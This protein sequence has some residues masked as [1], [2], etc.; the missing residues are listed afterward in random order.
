VRVEGAVRAGGDVRLWGTQLAFLDPNGNDNGVPLAARRFDDP[1]AGTTRLD[2][3]IGKAA[4]ATTW[5]GVGPLNAAGTGIDERL[6]VLASGNVG[7]GT[8]TPITALQVPERGIQ[9]GVSATATDNFHLVSDTSGGPRAFRL[10]NQN[11]GAGVHLVTFLPG[12]NVGIGTTNPVTALQVPE[13]GIQ[14]GTSGT[15]A[16]NFH[17]VSDTNA[18]RGLRLYNGNYGSGTLL[19]TVLPNG[20]VGVGAT[21]LN[22]ALKLDIQG[23]FGRANGPATL[24][25]WGSRVGDVGNGVLFLRSG[26]NVVAVDKA[27]DRFGVGTAAPGTTLEVAGDALLL[28]NNNPLLLNSGHT[29]FPNSSLNRAEISNDTGTWKALMIVGNRSAGEGG[30]FHLGR[31]VQVWDILEVPT[32]DARKPGGGSWGGTSDV[33]LKQNIRPLTDALETLLRLR[34]VCFEWKDPKNMGG[35]TGPQTGLIAQEVEAVFPGWVSTGADGYKVLTVRGFEA[36]AVEALRQ[37][38]A[39][40]AELR[41]RTD[42]L[43]QQGRAAGR[44]SGATLPPGP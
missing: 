6:V 26:G 40:I 16:D 38:R 36:L 32:G 25:L 24:N 18:A 31:K 44:P 13:R 15:A 39:E 10:Y 20:N 29:G 7:I 21:A 34:G 41:A 5:F 17:F 23:D 4:A 33:A 2:V 1:V 35:L 11:F 43:E 22:P 19:L 8:T 12:G 9:V 28:T 14:I 37:V 30:L 3:Q 27:G 42:A